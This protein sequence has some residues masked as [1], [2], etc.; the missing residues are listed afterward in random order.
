MNDKEKTKD[1]KNRQKIKNVTLRTAGALAFLALW[2]LAPLFMGNSA[3]LLATPL[4][5]IARLYELVTGGGFFAHIAFS[6]ARIALGFTLA[7][8][9]GVLFAALSARFSVA[10]AL[11]RPYITVS[12]TV[13]V[14]SFIV[15]ALI[16]L[17]SSAL[18]ECNITF[19]SGAKMREALSA[20]LGVL[21]GYEPKSVG[22]ALPDGGFYYE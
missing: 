12:K 5:V 20:Y 15:L 7:V 9:A 2:Q 10:E 13:P 11:I 3:V 1:I 4:Q 16:W 6:L 8:A 19:I 17:S 18:P 14:A 21:Y 22:G